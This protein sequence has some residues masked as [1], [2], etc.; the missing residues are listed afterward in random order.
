MET[1]AQEFP[2][3]CPCL[4]LLLI[5]L[6]AAPAQAA[7]P[8]PTSVKVAAQ[9][10]TGIR[11]QWAWKSG[12]S[13]YQVQAATDPSFATI[14]RDQTVR[15]KSKR[16]SGAKMAVTVQPLKNATKYSFRVR[17]RSGKTWSSWSSTVNGATKVAWPAKFTSVKGKAGPRAGQVTVSWEQSGASTT[18]FQL[19]TAIT[20]FSKTASSGLPKVGKNQR[21]FNVD[22]TKRS[23]TLSAAQVVDAGAAGG[24]GIHL[25]FR[26]YAI[27]KGTAGQQIRRYARLQA[28][29]PAARSSVTGGDSATTLGTVRAG[30]FNVRSAKAT[31]D[32]RNWL[33][34]R[35]D[36]AQ[37]IVDER[38]DVLALQELGPG[39]A[40]GLGGSTTGTM[41]QT[42]SL[43]DSL[44]KIGASRYLMVRTTPYVTAGTAHGSQGPRLLYNSDKVDLLSNCPDSTGGQSY[45]TSCA[46]EL[47]LLSGDPEGVR[48][49]AAYARFRIKSSGTQFFMVSVHLDAATARPQPRRQHTAGCEPARLRPS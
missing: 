6:L 33:Q 29:L 43:L 26:L 31:A 16:P 45:S 35:A 46:V 40:D 37:Q 14:A 17:A 9:Y 21:I 3:C 28:V 32:K 19:E 11:I 41:R 8:K 39:R 34:R 1:C 22:P 27:N 23:I 7:A 49:S 20:R 25:L 42:T 4:A 10:N 13:S 2:P 18:A 47:P 30:T 44:N 38:P 5:A 24:S 48:R 12:I 15:G 36:V